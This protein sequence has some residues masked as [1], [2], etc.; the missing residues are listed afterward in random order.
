M[1]NKDKDKK[2]EIEIRSVCERSTKHAIHY[3]Y[4][5]DMYICTYTCFS[6]PYVGLWAPCFGDGECDDPHAVCLQ[7]QC[8]CRS[9]YY[10]NRGRCGKCH[11]GCLNIG[12]GT[13][14]PSRSEWFI[15]DIGK[16]VYGLME[17]GIYIY[18]YVYSDPKYTIPHFLRITIIFLFIPP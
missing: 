8:Q 10:E 3:I 12:T 1:S 18:I 6:V 15:F 11:L 5:H 14:E 2:N 7:T 4:V 17:T 9:G 16:M 13:T